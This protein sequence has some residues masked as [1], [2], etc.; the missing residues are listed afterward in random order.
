VLR[1]LEISLNAS[2]DNLTALIRQS[3]EIEQLIVGAENG[4]R[5]IDALKT[6]LPPALIAARQNGRDLLARARER[7]RA[8]QKTQ[9]AALLTDAMRTANEAAAAFTDVVAQLR[10]LSRAALEREVTQSVAA[11]I[12]TLSFLDASFATFE[13]LTAEKAAV[14]PADAGARRDALEKRVSAIRRRFETA[15][16]TEN[17]NGIR[18]A[19]RLA[20][21][22]RGELD[23][24]ITSFGPLTLR[25]RGVHAALEDGARLF[26]AGEYRQALT[27]LD[28]GAL[29][30]APLQLHVH[31]LRAAAF[32]HLFVRSGERDAAL[33]TSAL[34]EVEACK[35]IAPAFTPDARAFAPRFLM[36]FQDAGRDTP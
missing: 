30:D 1:A 3:R 35:R 27:A 33:R 34:T 31:L 6:A 5:A 2:I 4:D 13:R 7:V 32:Y 9:N 24:L 14:A 28:A 25:D 16:R 29:A 23:T 11:G 10:A 20:A 36:F 19:T 15:R 12:E 17:I 18:D 8:G 26:F 21:E 22:A